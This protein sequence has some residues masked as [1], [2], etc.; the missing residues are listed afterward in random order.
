VQPKCLN[1]F[2]LINNLSNSVPN[3]S[4]L[5][6]TRM[7][8]NLRGLVHTIAHCPT[9]TSRL[10]YPQLVFGRTSK[11]SPKRL[12]RQQFLPAQQVSALLSSLFIAAFPGAVLFFMPVLHVLVKPMLLCLLPTCT[13]ARHQFW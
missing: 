9:G 13:G 8:S 10:L 1:W 7:Y 2:G 4:A 5:F 3:Q 6:R 11:D 12:S